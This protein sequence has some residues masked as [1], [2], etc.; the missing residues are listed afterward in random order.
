MPTRN[1]MQDECNEFV[2][3]DPTKTFSVTHFCLEPL[4]HEP[5][6]ICGVCGSEFKTKK[7]EESN[8]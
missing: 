4:N 1:E 7:E 2:K 8:V 3:V 5:P 6:H